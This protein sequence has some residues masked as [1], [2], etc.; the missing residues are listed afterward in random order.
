M[1][2]L[3]DF[4][5]E[6]V[7]PLQHHEEIKEESKI[8]TG[9]AEGFIIKDI[10]MKGFMRYVER[11][12]P[13]VSFPGKYTVITGKTGCGKT[14]ILDAITFALYKKTSRTDI[15]SIKISDVCQPGGYVS[16]SF[17]QGGEEY[18]VIR[19]FTSSSQPYLTLKKNGDN[20]EGNIRELEKII[21]E[22]I[23]LDYDS[24]RNSTFVRQDEMKELGAESGANR[25]EIFQKLF[26]LETFEKAQQ[27]V[28]Q[29]H[30]RLRKSINNLQTE[31]S[32]RSEQTA[33]LPNLEKEISEKKEQTE[34][35]KINLELMNTEFEKIN[36]ELEDLQK[37]HDEF[38]SKKGRL[39]SIEDRLN[40]TKTKYEKAK[41][42]KKR[43][44]P[45][46]KEISS[47]EK[48]IKEYEKL[49]SEGD[50][51]LKKEHTYQTLKNDLD[52]ESE[53][54]LSLIKE[55]EI[56]E[57]RL[58]KR[59]SDH[60][61]RIKKLSTQIGKD[62]AFSLLR[63]QGT[64]SERV[65]RIEK[66]LIWLSEN[67]E[68]VGELKEERKKA[69]EELKGVDKKVKKINVDSFVL[70]EIE[71]NIIQLKKD[72]DE[73][74]KN[75]NEKIQK[76]ELKLKEDKKRLNEIGFGEVEKKRITQIRSQI[77]EVQ[78][79]KNELEEKRKQL[80]KTGDLGNLIA[81]LESQKS[82]MAEEIKELKTNLRDLAASEENF[83]KTSKNLK[84]MQK[85]KEIIFGK[86]SRWEGEIARL[87][88][89]IKDLKELKKQIKE[90]EDELKTLQEKS[91]IYSILRE[92]VFHKRGIVMYA[93]DQLLPQLSLETSEN[94]SDMTDGRFSK[95]RLASYGENNRYGIRIEVAGSDGNWHDV[96]EFS[97][98]EKTQIN[99]A[100]RFAIAKELA[101]MPQVG[102][103][104]G[105]M[106][107]LFIDEGD[108]GSL[109]TESSRQLFV[110][111]LF[112]MGE[113]FEKII[114]ITHL[115]EVAEK[116]PHR[117]M[118][119]MTAEEESKIKVMS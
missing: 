90:S 56:E 99:A 32:V 70:S 81:D 102:R 43:V 36:K 48:E 35:E 24:F 15:Q 76:I 63:S 77:S 112:D 8:T 9:S 13:R 72:S 50:V 62:E 60:E 67:K 79:K 115:S 52:R 65:D 41:E 4:I 29:R 16:V 31:I 118:I 100:L 21:E 33:K 103:T 28:S 19:G 119:Y 59:I 84:K 113:F 3:E 20:I 116:F 14:S 27:L 23:G 61:K 55:Q 86:I 44:E 17:F 98:G 64:F 1:R 111:K 45:L 18:E 104:Y 106:K 80:E 25:L 85:E 94:L 71:S 75:Y 92:K 96:Q 114:L 38:S 30:D 51:L 82:N 97:G 53:L 34:K 95:V 89:Q 105:R 49:R 57:K 6:D 74:Q 47:L 2:T 26:R 83:Q 42:E 58:K 93:I 91:E 66:E 10:E 39:S 101:S 69:K 12:D 88:N 40:K 109:D 68:L 11:T 54:K 107:T 7:V 5:S 117:I 73:V 110:S 37:K 108:L 46:K 87:D 22:V 78:K